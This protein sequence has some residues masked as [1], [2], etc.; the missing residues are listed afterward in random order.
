MNIDP[1]LHLYLMSGLV[2]YSFFKGTGFQFLFVLVIYGAAWQ[3]SEYLSLQND[4]SIMLKILF[5]NSV[6]IALIYLIIQLEYTRFTSL[7]VLLLFINIINIFALMALDKFATVVFFDASLWLFNLI[8]IQLIY[9][10]LLALLGVT[11]G[12]GGGKR[13]YRDSQRINKRSYAMAVFHRDNIWG[14]TDCSKSLSLGKKQIKG[15]NR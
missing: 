6:S 4:A 9:L 13:T 15:R 14:N 3:M 2:V 10:D 1:L 8:N 7:F 12:M 11:F 5:Q